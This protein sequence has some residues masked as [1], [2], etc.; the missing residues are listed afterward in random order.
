MAT[1]KKIL[2]EIPKKTKKSL[3]LPDLRINKNILVAEHVKKELDKL[4]YAK[5]DYDAELE[6]LKYQYDHE[7]EERVGLHASAVSSGGKDFCYREQVLSLFYKMIQ[8]ENIPIGL[9]RIF[10][11]GK[12]IGTKWQRLFIRGGIAKKEDLDVSRIEEQY[13]LSYTPDAIITI[14]NKL[15]VVE[16][17]SQNT[18]IFKKQQSHPSGIK[19]LKLY[20]YFEGI[21]QGFVLVEDKNTQDYKV[22]IVTNVTADDPDI[23]D[24][25]D[26]L[27]T[28]QFYKEKFIRTKKPPKR[29]P[30]CTTHTCKR[31]EKCNMREACWNIGNGRIKI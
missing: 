14:D 16:I 23:S 12:S 2:K 4:F 3:S 20:M 9:K 13:D 24:I 8:G 30:N 25:I 7:E 11:E 28:I 26:R 31:A 6:M 17:K 5:P 15:Y 1:K 19:Q 18:F 21:E 22:L 29:L 27:E 10:E